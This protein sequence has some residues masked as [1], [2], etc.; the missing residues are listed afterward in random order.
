MHQ[1][2][3]S[4]C[5]FSDA[6]AEKILE[7]QNAMTVKTRK[8]KTHTECC[9]IEPKLKKDRA[10]RERNNPSFRIEFIQFDFFWTVKFISIFFNKVLK[11]LATGL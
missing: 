11:Y 2:R 7:I 4:T 5:L 9:E 1:L 3:I 6:K 10:K 8:K